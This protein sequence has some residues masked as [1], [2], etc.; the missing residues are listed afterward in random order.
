MKVALALRGHI[1]DGLIDSRLR[2]YIKKLVQARYVSG[3]D[4]YCHGW[5]EHEAKS[6]YRELDNDVKL[7]VTPELIKHYFGKELRGSIKNIQI[8]DDSK[9]EIIGN[10]EGLICK[11]KLPVI[12]W[13]RMWAGKKQLIDS[14]I[15]SGITYDRII[16]TRYDIFT[17]K[18]GRLDES[19]LTR[20]VRGTHSLNFKYPVYTR[21]AVGVDNFYTGRPDQMKMLT[22]AFYYKLDEILNTYPST[23]VQEKMVYDYA[24]DTGLIF[25]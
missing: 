23:E 14:V 7:K 4:I 17:C 9:I 13:K 5:K 19:I 16:N 6:S 12:A 21:G 18:A 24:R 8:Q 22:Y 3:L 2:D 11:T 20:L 25:R 10:T 15:N 1:R